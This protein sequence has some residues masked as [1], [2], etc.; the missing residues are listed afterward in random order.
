LQEEAEFAME[1]CIT[2]AQEI[3]DAERAARKGNPAPSLHM[4][5]TRQWVRERF[6]NLERG[7]MSNGV[8]RP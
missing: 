2:F 1:W 7:L 6:R 5:S 3:V 4:E 8:P